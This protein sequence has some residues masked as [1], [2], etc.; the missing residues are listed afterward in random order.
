MFYPR[1]RSVY[2]S[3]LLFTAGLNGL[4]SCNKTEFERPLVTE[5]N[6]AGNNVEALRVA[7]VAEGHAQALIQKITDTTKIYWTPNWNAG[8]DKADAKGVVYTYVPLQSRLRSDK[9]SRFHENLQTLGIERFILIKH[10]NIKKLFSL[11]T[12]IAPQSAPN[13]TASTPTSQPINFANFS[14][15]ITLRGLSGQ[16]NALF[17]YKNGLIVPPIAGKGLQKGDD[18]TNKLS[19]CINYTV[20]S[21][22][23]YCSTN[24]VYW[25]AETTGFD[26]ACSQPNSSAN[27]CISGTIPW[28]PIDQF[29]YPNCFSDTSPPLPNT[30]PGTIGDVP[31]GTYSTSPCDVLGFRTAYPG[32]AA[33]L[34]DLKSKVHLTYETGYLYKRSATSTMHAG[35]IITSFQQGAPGAA[36]IFFNIPSY[37]KY[38]G[39]SHTHYDSLLSIFSGSDLSALYTLY[40]EERMY[41]P[42]DFI[43]ELVTANGTVYAM[44]IENQDKF[45]AFGDRWFAN[46]TGWTVFEGLFY[47]MRYNINTTNTNAQNEINFMKLLKGFDSGL[48]LMRG[49]PNN[50][51][52]WTRLGLSPD[53]TLITSV[54]CP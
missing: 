11:A 18:G 32:Y 51:N 37:E 2:L 54:P 25:Y 15:V 8:Y 46:S 43:M 44:R 22:Y 45:T 20:C 23:G 27:F 4:S 30:N 7:F 34:S 12:C 53:E 13:S 14:G 48:S 41:D 6:G 40:K 17:S 9:S 19:S 47:N 5:V 29:T 50:F 28:S 42:E 26:G 24:Q 52:S 16:G 38:S 10:D 33:M 39:Y 35:A 1:L 3:T 21:W 36:G 31:N 49:D